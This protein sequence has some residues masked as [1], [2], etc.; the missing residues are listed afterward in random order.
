MDHQIKSK[1]STSLKLIALSF[2][3]DNKSYSSDTCSELLSNTYRSSF[4]SYPG[5]DVDQ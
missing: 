2:N 3:Q 5:Y 4:A 1:S